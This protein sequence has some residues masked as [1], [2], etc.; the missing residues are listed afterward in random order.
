M[1]IKQNKSG[2]PKESIFPMITDNNEYSKLYVEK[3]IWAKVK[4]TI[5]K[6]PFLANAISL[7]YCAMDT[8][9]P[10][11]ARAIAFSSL[12]YFILPIDIIPDAILAAGYSDDAGVIAAAILALAPFITEEHKR[13]AKDFLA[14]WK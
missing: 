4:K 9:T 2:T 11:K 6:V 5:G 13:K 7:Y 12:A 14:D 3:G 10:L 1:D 8:K